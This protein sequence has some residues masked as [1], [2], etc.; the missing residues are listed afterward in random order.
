[1]A[2]WFLTNNVRDGGFQ[3]YS[4]SRAISTSHL[5]DDVSFEEGSVI[6]LA[7]AT[8]VMGLYPSGR[9]ELPLPQATKPSPI[10]KV[11]LVWGGSS[12]T[13]SVAVQLAVASGATVVAT[14]SAK[15][16]KFVESLGATAVLDYNRETVVQDL[17]NTIKETPGDFV[18]ALDAI[19]EDQTWRACA[20]VVKAL[21]KTRVVTNLPAGYK[22][23]PEGIEIAAGRFRSYYAL[24]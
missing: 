17:I 12:S 16:H 23:V 3:H 1:M 24:Q 6:P 11:I 7:L 18:G 5:P 15:N 10:G 9:L 22:D 4:I 14:A 2:N 13:G 19:A 8:S 20:N 21:G